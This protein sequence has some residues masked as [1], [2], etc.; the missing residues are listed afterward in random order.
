[1]APVPVALGKNRAYSHCACFPLEIF[2]PVYII[3]YVAP[4]HAITSCKNTSSYT[5]TMSSLFN[6]WIQSHQEITYDSVDCLPW[7]DL[8]FFGLAKPSLL[9]RE[10]TYFAFLEETLKILFCPMLITYLLCCFHNGRKINFGVPAKF[11][12]WDYSSPCSKKFLASI[13]N[14]PC[15]MLGSL[16]HNAH[17][18]FLVG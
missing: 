4:S 11:Q 16:S 14:R 6:D 13:S 12:Y 15:R 3:L 10:G 8:R 18:M 5:L 7:A 17:Y 1:M 9:N 2:H